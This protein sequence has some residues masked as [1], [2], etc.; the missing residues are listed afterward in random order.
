MKNTEIFYPKTRDE[1]RSWLIENHANQNAVWVIFYKKGTEEPTITWRMAVDEALCF[2]WIDSV[3]KKRDDKS[4]I[5]FFSKRKPKSTWSKINKD[6]VVQLIEDG[7]MTEAG[8][9]SIEI[10]K[11]NGSW[12]ILDSVE[13]LIVPEDLE[14]Q[15]QKYPEA[16]LFYEG[17]SKSIKKMLLYWLISAKLPET[18][19]KRLDEIVGQA[20]VGKKPK[21]F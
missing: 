11:E 5:Q 17:L 10:T 6:I 15:F 20:R 19:K 4:S 18:R 1:W 9:R 7:L 21:Q 12:N 13:A 3:K 2:G 14:Q 8:Y 16:Q